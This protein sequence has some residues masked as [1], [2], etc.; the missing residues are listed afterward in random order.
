MFD[1]GKTKEQ[2]IA[3]LNDLRD[4]ELY[5]RKFSEFTSDFIHR[6]SKQGLE[7]YRITWLDGAV[8][9]VSGYTRYEVLKRGCWLN[10][11]HPEDLPRV[12]SHLL[13]LK[14]GESG[15]IEFRFVRKDGSMR[16]VAESYR[17]EAGEAPDELVLYGA[18]RD[19]SQ[20]RSEEKRL[21]MAMQSLENTRESVHW[22]DEDGRILYVNPA[23]ER[24]LGYTAGELLRM[25]I[26]DIDPN[27]PENQWG[28]G[29]SLTRVLKSTGLRKFETLHRHRDGHMIPVEVDSDGFYCDGQ[30]Y[31]IAIARDITERKQTEEALRASEQSYRELF[32]NSPIGIFLTDS[33]G[34][35]HRINPEMA[36]ML[37]FASP[38]EALAR[39]QDLANKLY[40]D[41]DRRAQ[42]LDLM[43]KDGEVSNFEFEAHDARGHRIW[44][45]MN[46]RIRET[47]PD[48]TFLI[49][50]F[51]LDV[52]ERKRTEEKLRENEATL[53]A[54]IESTSDW[55]WSVDPRDFALTLFNSALKEFFASHYGVAIQPGMT[56]GDLFPADRAGVWRGYYTRALTQG[57][58]Q[59]EYET[60]DASTTLL[61]SF[62]TVIQDNDVVSLVVL[63]KDIT[64]RRKIQEALIQS[65]KMMSVGGLAAGM[66]N[67]IN[68]PLSGILQNAQVV[69]RRL[70]PG[71]HDNQDA[72]QQAGTTLEAVLG[73]LER[74]GILAMLASMRSSATRAAQIVLSMLEFSRKADPGQSRVDV[75]GL[76]DK[77]V[78]LCSTDYDLKKRYDFRN[79]EIRREYDPDLGEVPC[80]PTQIQQV[81]I[82]L[83]RN[84]AQAM[85]ERGENAP[86]ARII[87]RTRR[88]ADMAV[89]EV[90]DN[91][92][93]ISED[94]R[95]RIFEPF[96]T[97]KPVGQGTGLGL[98]ISYFIVINNHGGT[99]E[100]DSQPGKG[101]RFTLRLPLEAL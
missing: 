84:S 39:L 12:S 15:T 24:E 31:F 26:P 72:A 82:N 90:E 6:C 99:I 75:S 46:A 60:M 42:F 63:G 16:W 38:E 30:T 32:D 70:E 18:I 55:V 11:I 33:L 37:G 4:K 14:A 71:R 86:A 96:F 93:G 40:A 23:M 8:E 17:C 35:A 81:I 49:D 73:Y 27:T 9:Q 47:L 97:T 54:V 43:R 76:L 85:H 87:L 94:M 77:S 10:I 69:L 36:R 61:L 29:G 45:S 48:G 44:L 20:R 64:E 88:E 3:E 56:P 83:L 1:S 101:T 89:V 5:Y 21:R 91:G 80:A 67:E 28:P 95:R 59:T 79:I 62:D 34:R 92:P 65:E 51:L 22:I 53:S 52:T 25:S 66:A 50:G 58:F 78:E 68:N 57:T 100:V 41:P 74:R 13:A 19:I 2:L 98:S 7:S